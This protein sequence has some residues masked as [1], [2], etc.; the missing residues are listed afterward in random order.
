GMSIGNSQ[1]FPTAA[2]MRQALR[3]ASQPVAAKETELITPQPT[4]QELPPT[5]I[6][7][8]IIAQEI[9]LTIGS[10]A[11]HRQ[12]E[13]DVTVRAPYATYETARSFEPPQLSTPW[14]AQPARKSKPFPWALVAFSLG[15]LLLIGVVALVALRSGTSGV[16]ETTNN[17]STTTLNVNTSVTTSNPS[18]VNFNATPDRFNPY[19]GKLSDLLP[20]TVGV[21]FRT[22][23][24]DE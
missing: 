24:L 18:S 8:E 19:T 10:P 14:P 11:F 4:S 16:S 22:F 1:R 12:E 5:R 13:R 15:M 9:P 17:A 23:T 21:G 2:E 20:R 6:A 3:N 7:E